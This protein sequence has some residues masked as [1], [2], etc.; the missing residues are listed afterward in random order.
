L[1]LVKQLSRVSGRDFRV[2]Q[3]HASWEGLCSLAA[4]SVL[5]TLPQGT[6]KTYVSQLVAYA[7]LQRNQGAKVLVVVPTRELREQYVDMAGW[8]G[9]DLDERLVVVSF[10]ERL[11]NMRSAAAAMVEDAHIVV[12]TPQLFANRLSCFSKRS[13]KAISLCI[14]DEIDLWPIED[15]EEDEG[16]R[17]HDSFAAL[18]ACLNGRTIRFL[19]LTASPLT[20]RGR[21]LLLGEL[22]CKELHPFH[23]TVIPHL[24]MVRIEP[25]ACF[26]SRII[27]LDAEISKSNK[28]LFRR[29]GKEVGFHI[30]E[31]HQDDF[32]VYVKTL[33]GGREGQQARRLA[34]AL[35]DNQ[36]KR[37]QLF[38]DIL[39]RRQVKVTCAKDIA[40]ANQ[41]S[42]IF[43]REI[44]LVKCFA[45]AN[46][47]PFEVAIAH[48]EMGDRYSAEIAKFKSGHR[49]VLL[50]TRDLGKRG[51]DFPMASS[52]VLCS[53]KSSWRTMDQE[54]CRTRSNRE[55][56]KRVYVLF[57]ERTYEE[58]KLRRVITK[59][60]GMQM[61][62]RFT[63]YTLSRYWTKWL[64]AE[65][66]LTPVEY[67]SA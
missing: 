37:N 54:M 40:Q 15:F 67:L 41:P 32:W 35:L 13:L 56:E 49:R 55:K 7:Y 58:A 66:P 17:F 42:V 33:A 23:R 27:A 19:G 30:L 11:A 65:K 47:W 60:I 45:K 31:M 8:M 26:D 53:P 36:R 48:S 52:L 24:P 20:N 39:P 4:G 28:E 61:Y 5:M 43:C 62:R 46:G 1:R 63:K 18:R 25:I 57:Y 59:L 2:Y 38:E 6:G 29:L 21:T 44:R 14:L 3:A 51:L 16:V 9:Q 50:I 10:D 12:T 34:L 22:G 64:L